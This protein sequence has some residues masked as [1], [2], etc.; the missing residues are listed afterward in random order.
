MYA[1]PIVTKINKCHL[2]A[3]PPA[4]PRANSQQDKSTPVPEEQVLN[5]TP[6]Q[7]KIVAYKIHPKIESRPPATYSNTQSRS[8]ISRPNPCPQI[9][10]VECKLKDQFSHDKNNNQMSDSLAVPSR[11]N[12]QSLSPIS[13]IGT[14]TSRISTNNTI[15]SP[16]IHYT[17]P[18]ESPTQVSSIDCYYHKPKSRSRAATFTKALPWQHASDSSN[19]DTCTSSNCLSD[20]Q[21]LDSSNSTFVETLVTKAPLLAVQDNHQYWSMHKA[22]TYS[23]KDVSSL[24]EDLVIAK[25]L[26]NVKSAQNDCLNTL[27][28]PTYSI[29]QPQIQQKT[30]YTPKEFN[31]NPNSSKFQSSHHREYQQTEALCPIRMIR[32]ELTES[33]VKSPLSPTLPPRHNRSVAPRLKWSASPVKSMSETRPPVKLTDES[34][35]FIT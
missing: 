23:E 32:D 28:S 16:L 27:K 22:E 5:N 17:S 25:E 35:I 21:D 15:S 3:P 9:E 10:I 30:H 8:D 13:T 33:P 24:S 11:V 18:A 7:C 31:C 2:H 12:K 26:P 34:Y 4:P 6:K 20:T 1:T 29:S 19:D 14:K